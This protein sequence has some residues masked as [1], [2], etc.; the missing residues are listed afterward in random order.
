MATEPPTLHTLMA[1]GRALAGTPSVGLLSLIL[2]FQVGLSWMLLRNTAFQDEALYVFAGRQIWSH[3]VHGVPLLDDFSFYMS[4]NPYV[5]PV[6][7]GPLDRV[8]GVE[9]VRAL[10]TLLMLIVTVCGYYVTRS[11][12]DRKAALLAAVFFAVQGPVL[13]LSRLATYDPLCL[14]ALALAVALLVY[15]GESRRVWFALGLGPLLVLA[16]FSKYLA[17]VYVPSVLLLLFLWT[18]H[19]WGW[20]EAAKGVAIG[21]GSLVVVGALTALVVAKWDPT[22]MHGLTA[23]TTNRVVESTYPRSQL[24]VHGLQLVGVSFAAAIIGF[25]LAV[26]KSNRMSAVICLILLG[27]SFLV[28]A[29]HLY[30]AEPTSFDKH[31]AYSMFFAM[32]L[33][34]YLLATLAGRRKSWEPN[35]YWLSSIAIVLMLLSIGIRNAQYMYST[36]PASD[37]V[38]YVMRTQVRPASG[39]YMAESRDVVRYYLQDVTYTW[40]WTGPYFFQYT[41]AQGHYYAGQEAYVHAIDDGY[42]D[43]VELDYQSGALP[44]DLLIAKTI[45]SSHRYDLIASI[46][47]SDVYG[48]GYYFIYRKK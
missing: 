14:C 28:P 12:F 46:P 25:M 6:L 21:V 17:V 27:A 2:A 38:T 5:Y 40:Q 19:R 34:G 48:T 18:L 10:S 43:V 39:R 44:L 22:M 13:F 1:R 29:Y 45:E 23:S 47:N 3:W 9:L 4:G 11:L 16:F 33:A 41:D 7:A 42:F 26:R 30:K 24:V 31:F 32:P 37:N 8:G 36:W 20:R 35:G 15:V